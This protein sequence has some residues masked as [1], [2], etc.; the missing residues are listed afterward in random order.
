LQVV[1]N[2]LGGSVDGSGAGTRA[3][4]TVTEAIRAAGG[5]AV[6]S[7]DSVDQGP[8]IVKT[9]MDAFGRVDAVVANAGIL[10][11]ASFG[12]M[13][14]AAWDAVYQVHVKGAYS[15]IR[16]AWPSMREQRFG[17]VVLVSSS[18]GLYG[19]FGQAN[20]GAAKGAALGLASALSVEGAARGI[21]VN[22]ISP[23]AA[24]R[25]TEGL[26]PPD[27]LEALQPAAVAPVVAYLCSRACKHTGR[28]VEVGAGWSAGVRWQRSEA[29]RLAPAAAAADEPLSLERVAAAWP[30]INDWDTAS[31][32]PTST[33]S[34]FEPIM[35]ALAGSGAAQAHTDDYDQVGEALRQTP[36]SPSAPPSAWRMLPG[37]SGGARGKSESVDAARACAATLRTVTSEYAGRD[38]A[39]Y[40]LA[41]GALTGPER[42]LDE[43]DLCLLYDGCGD[44]DIQQVLPSQAVLWPHSVLED[45]PSVPGLEFDPTMLLHGEQ[46]LVIARSPVDGLPV[47]LPA[48]GTISTSARIRGVFDKGSGALVIADA[49]T[50]AAASGEALA[51]NRIS[52][53]IRGVG[54][55]GGDRGPVFEGG[56]ADVG[57]PTGQ[58][59]AVAEWRVP[60]AAAALYR[61]CGDTNPL[62]VNPSFAQAGGF[63][64][65][66]LHGLASFG[67]AT[68]HIVRCACAGDVRRVARIRGRFTKHVFPGDTLVTQMWSVGPSKWAEDCDIVA[69]RCLVVRSE[70]GPD[71]VSE[72]VSR[73]EAHIVRGSGGLSLRS[74]IAAARSSKL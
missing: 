31:S 49:V 38:S 51:A 47:G 58:P 39:L 20:Y 17:R 43:K 34:A 59:H 73:G 65:P 27:L 67:A 60:H 61:L 45:L 10:R 52:I 33:Q 63:E 11:D 19:N 15:V 69:F 41:V 2:D 66:I 1:V 35:A 5:R 3:A 4:D 62:H 44:Y 24:S 36:P 26:M 28:V 32:H 71:S 37:V 29:F 46:D 14:R 13:S 53:F 55:F 48:S 74:D 6:P 40:A 30:S 42:A 12:K 72:A 8:K 18:T 23:I 21:N 54:G 57:A 9:A 22:V 7:Y 16:A 68:R 64:R 56:D 50:S 70:P 25:M